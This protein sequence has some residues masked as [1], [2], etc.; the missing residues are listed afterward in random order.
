MPLYGLPR[1]S[2]SATVDSVTATTSPVLVAAAKPS[3]TGLIIRALAG[4]VYVGGSGVSVAAGLKLDS[5]E[6]LS[7]SHRGAVY[8]ITATGTAELRVLE[9]G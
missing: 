6:S 2:D 4:P 7:I 5:G 9:E 8:A 3:R 1:Y